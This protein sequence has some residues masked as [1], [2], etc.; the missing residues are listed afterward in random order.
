M[1]MIASNLR[2]VVKIQYIG[3]MHRAVTGM[4]LILHERLAF[5]R[6]SSSLS[7][8]GIT[9]SLKVYLYHSWEGKENEQGFHRRG[10]GLS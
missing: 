9:S 3:N 6:L 4:Q 7:L 1:G 2:A 10:S 5:V 8:P